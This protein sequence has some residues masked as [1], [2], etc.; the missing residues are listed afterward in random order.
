MEELL[1]DY[2]GTLLLVSHDRRFIDNTVTHSWLFEGNGRITPYVGGYADLVYQREQYLT[3]QAN[4]AAAAKTVSESVSK[5][6]TQTTTKKIV[7]FRIN[8]S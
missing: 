8:C 7:N 3:R 1:A 5:N 2:Q 4:S 6:E